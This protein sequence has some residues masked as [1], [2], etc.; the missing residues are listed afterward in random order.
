M[1]KTEEKALFALEEKFED[2][3]SDP[4]LSSFQRLLKMQEAVRAMQTVVL[5]GFAVDHR[6]GQHL[7]ELALDYLER[8]DVAPETVT[9]AFAAAR[10]TESLHGH[11]MHG[12]LSHAVRTIQ[13]RVAPALSTLSR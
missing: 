8:E 3:A 11:L 9:Q 6:L 7:A 4:L 2:A 13:N 1:F 5:Q 10:A 12:T